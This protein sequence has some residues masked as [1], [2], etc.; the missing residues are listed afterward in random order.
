[1]V[2]RGSRLVGTVVLDVGNA[3][4]VGVLL[5][6]RFGCGALFGCPC[7]GSVG[8]GLIR[9][10]AIGGGLV[11]SSLVSGGPVGGS[12]VRGG[13]V[14]S[15]LGCGSLVV[16]GLLVGGSFL[17]RQIG[18]RDAARVDAESKSA[19]EAIRRRAGRVVEPGAAREVEHEAGAKA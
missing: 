5:R 12:F 17:R 13:L 10:G 6:G 3:V 9:G 18:R 11:G 1:M 14:G 19:D 7:C 2:R 16:R 15:G 4:A 8:S